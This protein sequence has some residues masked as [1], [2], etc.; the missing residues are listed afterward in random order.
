MVETCAHLHQRPKRNP[1]MHPPVGPILETGLN[2]H[3]L[4]AASVPRQDP[5]LA[6]SP[7]MVAFPALNRTKR[8][9]LKPVMCQPAG[10]TLETGLSA[11]CHAEV[12]VPKPG[13][14]FA[15]NP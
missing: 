3:C 6:L 9:K 2:A 4:V 8:R 15:L 10:L 5:S 7:K 11:L 14:S 12:L 13:P 1:V